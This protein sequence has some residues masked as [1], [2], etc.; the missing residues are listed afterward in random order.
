[1]GGL[2][3]MLP[4]DC[5]SKILSF[6]SP[7]DTFR[8]SMVSS[9]FHSAVESDVV[10]E[11]FLPTD[12]KDVVSRLITPLTFTTKKELVVSLCNH[13]LIDGEIHGKINTQILSPNTRYGAYL[14][15]KI[16]NR[17]YGLNSIPSEVSIEVGNKVCNGMAYLRREDGMKQQIECMFY[18]NRIEVLRKRVIEGTQ[19]T[20]NEREDGW[21][22]IELG[23]FFN[24]EANE[25]IKMSLMEV[26]GYQ[27]KGGLIIEGIEV[28]PKH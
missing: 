8:S 16:S 25:E 4:G 24:G 10:W 9:M 21:M 13:V 6:N 14:I 15:M 1:M 3:D 27:L 19:R 23:E 5:V 12:Y 2:I 20:S 17:A 18:R 7:A 11:M 26:K 22:E 28:R